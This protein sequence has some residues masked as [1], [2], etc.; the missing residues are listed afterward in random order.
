MEKS[1]LLAK[2]LRSSNV[3]VDGMYIQLSDFQ[4][5][6]LPTIAAI[7]CRD[8]GQKHVLNRNNIFS[9]SM[10]NQSENIY[11]NEKERRLRVRF[12]EIKSATNIS[13]T[14]NKE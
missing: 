14:H 12:N 6:V 11:I 10:K 8:H 2:V 9:V 7:K 13:K 5:V 4:H 3:N 1:N